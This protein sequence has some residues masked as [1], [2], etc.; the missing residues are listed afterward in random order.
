MASITPNIQ[1]DRL[2]ALGT[3]PAGPI[4]MHM[5][6]GGARVETAAK[7]NASGAVVKVRTGNLRSSIHTEIHIRGTILVVAVNADAA[8]ALPVHEG[9]KAHDIV[10][11]R[12][13]VLT[14]Q[15]A[16]GQ[17]FAASVRHPGT[18][19][20]PFLRDALPAF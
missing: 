3:S 18:K 11:T 19:G 8:Y 4:Y 7:R 2:M 13:K 16:G 14:W 15:G 17:M 20:R 5:V 9:Q 6:A 10:P 1:A 12:A